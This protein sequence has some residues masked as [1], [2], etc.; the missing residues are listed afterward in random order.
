MSR[1]VPDAAYN[2]KAPM[3]TVEPVYSYPLKNVPGFSVV[4]LRVTYPPGAEHPP[5]RHG[6]ASVIGMVL[7][8]STYN[9]M[10]QGR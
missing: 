5:H 9:K 8:G 6:G 2:R 7:S 10:N 4:A 1:Q 3:P